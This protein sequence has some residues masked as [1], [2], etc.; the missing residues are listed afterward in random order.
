MAARHEH[1]YKVHVW[2][3]LSWK[4]VT[5]IHIFTGIMKSEYYCTILGEHLLPFIEEKFP[6]GQLLQQDNCKIHNSR[7]TTAF[8]EE[9]HVQVMPF[10]DQ[11]P[12]L[13]PIEN[14]GRAE[15]MVAEC[16]QAP[17]QAGTHRWDP[18]VLE[19]EGDTQQMPQL[20]HLRAEGHE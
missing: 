7:A 11:S 19:Y 6:E 5:N 13:N 15:A 4:V 2:A 18:A 20:L 17:N 3:G 12:D 9:S 1:P 8:L 14:V 10:P 16:A